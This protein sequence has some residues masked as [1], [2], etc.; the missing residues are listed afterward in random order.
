LAHIE[1]YFNQSRQRLKKSDWIT[2][3]FL[4]WSGHIR[5]RKLQHRREC[6]KLHAV[7]S[8]QIETG[9]ELKQET[10][11]LLPGTLHSIGQT[12]TNEGLEMI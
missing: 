8:R 9:D 6:D 11:I 1:K 5:N 10:M 4:F 2:K 3:T 7:Q 12:P